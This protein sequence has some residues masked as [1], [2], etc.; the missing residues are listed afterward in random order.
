MRDNLQRQL[1]AF[2][3]ATGAPMP[4][5]MARHALT[6][7]L[8]LE[9]LY[10]EDAPTNDNT[11]LHDPAF[12]ETL[13][14]SSLHVTPSSPFPP[15]QAAAS[16]NSYDHTIGENG[17]SILEPASDHTAACRALEV[18]VHLLDAAGFPPAFVFV[19]D[20]AWLLLDSLWA[21]I[22][23]PLLGV[24]CLLEADLNCWHLQRQSP[25]AYIGGNF[26]APHRDLAFDQC[27]DE[28]E[29]F[30]SLT[31]W[32]PINRSGATATNGCV[33]VVPIEH[34]DFFYSP[35]HPAHQR[36]MKSPS[37]VGLT[38]RAGHV[39]TWVPSLVH[40][41]TACDEGSE[42]EP[43]M[44]IGATFRRS[45]AKRSEFVAGETPTGPQPLQRGQLAQLTL[46]RRLAYVAKA[47]LAYSHWYPGMPGLHL[48][49]S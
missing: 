26:G 44:S 18:A 10:F 39:A 25:S 42:S 3:A 41:G 49:E 24:G 16:V 43:R 48:D 23:E 19:F 27:H 1:D 36:S 35:H 5:A 40:W 12:W 14:H 46:Q 47:L 17:F 29:C 8:V 20:E 38:L 37:S 28:D 2:E 6:Q 33:H 34:D 15:S 11:R 7:L 4:A 30:T 13:V 31:C 9:K 32:V 45:T 21:E 22:F